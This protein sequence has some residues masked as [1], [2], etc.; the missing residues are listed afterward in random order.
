M[1][2]TC[3]QSD[4]FTPL[5]AACETGK[6]ECVDL[7]LQ[8]DATTDLAATDGRTSLFAACKYGKVSC[9]RLLLAAGADVDLPMEDG[10]TPY[11]ALV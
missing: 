5:Y 2:R 6:H 10:T 7:L 1:P 9:V 3:S 4:G 8:S 11:A